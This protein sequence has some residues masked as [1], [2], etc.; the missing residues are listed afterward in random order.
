MHRIQMPKKDWVAQAATAGGFYVRVLPVEFTA[1]N[2]EVMVE[3]VE[4]KLDHKPT[5]KETAELEAKWLTACKRW[6]TL[7]ICGHAQSPA[8]K[9]FTIGGVSGWLNSEQRVSI[10]RS[11]ADK[12]AAGRE[13][14]TV[15][16]AGKGFTM[17]PTKA[18]EIL[19]AVEVY[20]SDCYDVTEN[21][22][23]AVEALT[24]AASVEAYDYASGYPK[25][26]TFEL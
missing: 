13:S 6:K 17:S 3:S 14:V 21:H 2:G 7:E 23:A 10:R 16:L 5:K 25:Q 11:A 9:A 8:V 24:D 12:V 20:A 26:L 1:E 4:F 19:A 15:Y 22:K 18:E